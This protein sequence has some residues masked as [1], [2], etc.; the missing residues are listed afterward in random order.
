MDRQERVAAAK[1]MF[2]ACCELDGYGLCVT[3]ENLMAKTLAEWHDVTPQ[4]VYEDYDE[5]SEDD[6]L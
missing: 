5:D 2:V 1:A 6:E 3:D 4:E